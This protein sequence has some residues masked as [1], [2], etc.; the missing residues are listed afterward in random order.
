MVATV[1]SFPYNSPLLYWTIDM[2]DTYL[3]KSEI[4]IKY[5]SKVMEPLALWLIR[6]GV[7]YKD[8]NSNL[9]RIFYKQSL[10]ESQRLGVKVTDSSLSLLAGLNRRDVTFF[11][12]APIS[13][14]IIQT[15]ST[16]SRVITLWIQK[17]WDKKIAF[18]GNI[19][20]FEALAKEVS[21]D[22]HP[23]TILSDLQ[24]LGL[25]TEIGNT[26][27]LLSDSFTPSNSLSKCQSLLSISVTDHLNSGL[28][29]I[30]EEKNSY[31]E[32]NLHADELSPESIEELR[33][34]SNEL[35]RELSHK[36]LDKAIEC[37]NRDKGKLNAYYRFSLGI[38]Q[39]NEFQ[40]PDEEK[41]E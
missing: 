9:K 2:P 38:Y 1:L 8:F 22:T 39:Y 11:K 21:Q 14:P 7:G 36:L 40:Y 12:D 26:V 33:I 6:S 37:S 5:V 32:Q 18:S 15:L 3:E 13:D 25:V 41:Q 10:N 31:L 35:W 30:F 19:N 34:L 28:V 27:I 17:K 29:N 20:S 4:A 16:S 24:R 23:R